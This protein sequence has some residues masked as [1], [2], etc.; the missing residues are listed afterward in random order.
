MNSFCFLSA[1]LICFKSHPGITGRKGGGQRN[2]RERV[3][4]IWFLELGWRGWW[5]KKVEK[6]LECRAWGWGGVY[7]ESEYLEYIQNFTITPICVA[8]RGHW[9]HS[10]VF[11]FCLWWGSDLRLADTVVNDCSWFVCDVLVEHVGNWENWR[12]TA[13]VVV[14]VQSEG[15]T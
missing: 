11:S 2:Y 6:C 13:V 4:H 14:S 5:N 15:L 10:L 8:F 12:C 9:M 1:I 3:G 7:K